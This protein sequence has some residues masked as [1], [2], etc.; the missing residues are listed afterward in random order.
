MKARQTKEAKEAKE[1]KTVNYSDK[2]ELFF[3][4]IGTI[5]RDLIRRIN[6]DAA[7]REVKFSDNDA[8]LLYMIP[9]RYLKIPVG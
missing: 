7:F 4:Q 6:K 3:A 8:Y 9:Y 5:Y 2:Y 1:A